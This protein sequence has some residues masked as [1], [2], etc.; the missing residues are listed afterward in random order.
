MD[1]QKQP[2][3]SDFPKIAG[4]SDHDERLAL[5]AWPPSFLRQFPSGPID[6]DLLYRNCRAHAEKKFSERYDT[7]ERHNKS[8]RT[9]M[10]ADA[11]TVSDLTT[12]CC[13]FMCEVLE[14]HADR[15]LDDGEAGDM[16]LNHFDQ[17][18]NR[19]VKETHDNKWWPGLQ[20]ISLG[21][22]G[23]SDAFWRATRE[24]I[25][26][27]RSKFARLMWD[28]ELKRTDESLYRPPPSTSSLSL[29]PKDSVEED[30]TDTL[31]AGE[32][33]SER[34]TRSGEVASQATSVPEGR[35]AARKAVVL[36]I[37]EER[38]WSVLDWA[39]NS[40][41]DFHTANDYLKGRTKPYRSTRKKL[42]ES[43]NLDAHQLPS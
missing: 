43:L 1:T 4:R 14:Y 3:D 33:E 37:L 12:C 6:P 16:A 35:Q 11:L 2:A 5:I 8:K 18:A 21:Q 13:S 36:P 29:V 17:F 42:A 32:M 24:I 19:L 23:R 38:G 20:A 26:C 28:A 40:G 22:E 7:W 31:T 15:L 25:S 39:T 10:R 9:E 30:K 41:V 34:T 27:V